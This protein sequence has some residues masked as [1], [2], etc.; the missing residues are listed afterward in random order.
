MPSGQYAQT[1]A[2]QG[3]NV[4][5]EDLCTCPPFDINISLISPSTAAHDQ[6]STINGSINKG[7]PSR[8]QPVRPSCP[9][10]AAMLHLLYLYTEPMN[11]SCCQSS[12]ESLVMQ[13][14][15]IQ[16]YRT[17]VRLMSSM[18]SRKDFVSWDGSI[19]TFMA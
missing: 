16:R 14:E 8:Q 19:P 11:D 2:T 4:N 3:R 17:C 12:V 15:S 10:V 18:A 7:F 5:L 9:L 1:I 6:E 13:R